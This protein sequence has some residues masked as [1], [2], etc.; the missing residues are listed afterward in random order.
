MAKSDLFK[1]TLEAGT[2]FLD[3]SRERAETVVKE[4]VEAGDLRK[5]RAQQAIDDVLARS[6]K[7]TDELR[8]LVRREIREQLG[9]MGVAT[10][11]DLARLEAKIDELR[12]AQA[13]PQGPA[14]ASA[15]TR[16]A[17]PRVKKMAKAAKGAPVTKGAAIRKA[18]KAAPAKKVSAAEPAPEAAAEPTAPGDGT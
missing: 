16:P 15:P 11:D 18:A 2:S 5:G 6:R 7:V 14:E 1:R 10:T 8:D 17:A 4:W 12:S 13:P 9:A 3:M